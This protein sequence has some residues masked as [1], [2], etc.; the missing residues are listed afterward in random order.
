LAFSACEFLVLN[1]STGWS[2]GDESDFEC[3]Q[4]FNTMCIWA[5]IVA[6][7][8]DF[9][10]YTDFCRRWYRVILVLM[11]E[12]VMLLQIQVCLVCLCMVS[13]LIDATVHLSLSMGDNFD[14]MKG[15]AAFLLDTCV[16]ATAFLLSFN[17]SLD[18]VLRFVKMDVRSLSVELENLR[19]KLHVL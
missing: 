7:V 6:I 14:A 5:A 9:I 17:N 16:I 10:I 12:N 18:W 13:C 1:F 3:H 4:S 15:T 2:A 19:Y 11:E 8:F